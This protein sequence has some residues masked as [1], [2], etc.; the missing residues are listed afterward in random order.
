MSLCVF[1]VMGKKELKKARLGVERRSQYG[2]S[3]LEGKSAEA[4]FICTYNLLRYRKE[5]GKSVP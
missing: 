4:L 5:L 3:G 2:S 1:T